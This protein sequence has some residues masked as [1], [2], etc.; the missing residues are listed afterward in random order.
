MCGLRVPALFTPRIHGPLCYT[1]K[2]I[3]DQMLL[4]ARVLREA[5]GAVTW[6]FPADFQGF[7]SR[8][9]HMEGDLALAI[10]LAL[11]QGPA[12]CVIWTNELPKD[13][14]PTKDASVEAIQDALLTTLG[15]NS[16]ASDTAMGQLN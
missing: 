1:H 15:T 9:L 10:L 8:P 7:C 3:Y 14:R 2:K 5:R 16:G 6:L 11:V 12:A 13:G 4:E